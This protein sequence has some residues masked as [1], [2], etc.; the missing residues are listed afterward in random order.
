[1]Q[2]CCIEQSLNFLADPTQPSCLAPDYQSPHGGHANQHSKSPG[3]PPQV[4]CSGLWEFAHTIPSA[5]ET[6][7]CT[8]SLCCLSPYI[9]TCREP[10]L[11][12]Q[13][14]WDVLSSY[15]STWPPRGSESS[16]PYGVPLHKPTPCTTSS[17]VILSYF[18]YKPPWSLINKT[19]TRPFTTSCNLAGV[20]VES[21]NFPGPHLEMHSAW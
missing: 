3:V 11:T 10:S 5:W 8:P 20:L 15:E 13:V 6:L 19:C 14:P 2:F 18:Y 7:P 21:G 12:F 16:L 9:L 17:T 1:M 4:V